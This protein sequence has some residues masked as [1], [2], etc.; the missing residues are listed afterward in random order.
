M[1]NKTKCEWEFSHNS[2]ID[3]PNY[4]K[5]KNCGRIKRSDLP[6]TQPCT[7]S[8]AAYQSLL[9]KILGQDVEEKDVKDF[10][11]HKELEIEEE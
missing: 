4:L 6:D 5:C 7:G 2:K 1:K 9:K 8:N 11:N 3:K 10:E